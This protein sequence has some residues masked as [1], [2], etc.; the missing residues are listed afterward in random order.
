MMINNE[1]ERR[2]IMRKP[3]V[4]FVDL[5]KN[6]GSKQIIKGLTF[7]LYEGEVFGFLGPN[8]AGKT[9][10]IRMMLGL[11]SITKGNVFIDG[12]NVKTDFEA[13]I[14]NVGGIVENPEMYKHMSGYQNLLHYARMHGEVDK[15]KIDEIVRQVGL[16][17]RIKDKVKTYSLGMR[18]RLGL[19]QALLH[20]PKII[21]LDEPT[22]GLDPAGIKELRDYLRN[23]AK[24]RNIAVLVSSHILSEMELMCDRFGIIQNG[25]LI[26]IEN[27]RSTDIEENGKDEYIIDCDKREK[28]RKI[29]LEMKNIDSEDS[30]VT[31]H[32]GENVSEL[33]IY[34]KKEDM[35]EVIQTLCKQEIAIYEVKKI[36]KTLE[37]Q[38]IELTGGDEIG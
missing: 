7:D 8:G 13:A 37:D 18:Q 25:E 27:I 31:P 10:T 5:H 23:L 32:E 36:H 29:L 1:D 11:I 22:N 35:P 24:E 4:Q 19:A 2:S 16:Q 14:K 21:V 28:A 26:K 17:N 6:I 33:R 30:S 9:T 34:S 20:E 12:K 3:I 38:F 15:K